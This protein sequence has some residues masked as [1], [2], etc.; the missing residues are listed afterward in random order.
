MVKLLSSKQEND[1]NQYCFLIGKIPKENVNLHQSSKI[2]IDDAGI[3]LHKHDPEKIVVHVQPLC[4]EPLPIEKDLLKFST[5]CYVTTDNKNKGFYP[6]NRYDDVQERMAYLKENFEGKLILFRPKLTRRRE[7]EPSFDTSP[8]HYNFNYV[9]KEDATEEELN[10]TYVAIPKYDKTKTHTQF[11][12]TLKT[13][14]PFQLKFHPSA[15]MDTPEFIYCDGY[16]YNIKNTDTLKPS[17]QNIFTYYA[18]NPEEITRIK[19]PDDWN[20][21]TKLAIEELVFVS[22]KKVQELI[23]L[24]DEKG[25]SITKIG[26]ENDA[27]EII[28]SQEEYSLKN[29]EDL[30]QAEVKSSIKEYEFLEK[31]KQTVAKRGLHLSDETL[32]NFHT[33]MKTS[34][35]NIIGGMT[36]TGKSQLVR[37][38]ADALGLTGKGKDFDFLYIPISP[39]YTEPADVL[40]YLNQQTGIFMESETRLVSFLRRASENQERM[41]LV[42]L[43][44]INLGQVEHYFS[45][46]L[47]LLEMDEE[48]RVLR[49]FSE[50][51]FCHDENLRIGIPIRDNILIIGTAN[52]DETTRDFSPRLLDRCNVIT[53]EKQPFSELLEHELG[54]KSELMPISRI[55]KADFRDNWTKPTRGFG[56]LKRE[57][58]ILLDKLHEVLS[59]FD[60][61]TGVSFRIAHSISRYM[62][63]I[64]EDEEQR[65]M[66]KRQRAF[67]Y[68]IKQRIL[69]KIRGHRDQLEMLIGYYDF[70][71]SKYYAGKLYQTLEEYKEELLEDISLCFIEKKAKELTRNGYTL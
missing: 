21:M 37:A 25:V 60:S 40:G 69:T 38:Y 8:Y 66:I 47:S 36:G 13:K 46:F 22:R 56:G 39:S 7:D 35:I 63:N 5:S 53:L 62:L 49:L 23:D 59:E 4:A 6:N 11:E 52:F 18:V 41:F 12:H 51:S 17:P 43:D 68:Q 27:E 71:Q 20:S 9:L 10:D 55:Q 50:T 61:Q 26:N 19:A 67:D 31:F 58:L 32:F 34:M 30:K 29:I 33:C 3:T 14:K 15:Y 16:L 64:P 44:E 45:P 54:E 70:E 28:Q 24:V 57:E 42:L 1:I 65:K 2:G 48:D